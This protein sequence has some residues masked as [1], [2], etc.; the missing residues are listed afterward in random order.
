MAYARRNPYLY[1]TWVSQ[2][3][4]RRQVVPVGLLVQ[5]RTT[6]AMTG[7][8]VRLR[9]PPAGTMEHTDLL[10]ELVAELEEQGCELFIERQNSLSGRK[11]PAQAPW[12][13]E[14]R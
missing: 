10:N 1:A 7:C 6:R 8:P 4:Y 13:A 12:S 11:S 2:I 14:S 9:R 3:P 5:G